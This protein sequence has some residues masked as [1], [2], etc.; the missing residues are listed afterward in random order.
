MDMY[1]TLAPRRAEFTFFSSK[2]WIFTKR[3]H[4]EHEISPQKFQRTVNKRSDTVAREIFEHCLGYYLSGNVPNIFVCDKSNDEIIS[5]NDIYVE[6]L[7]QS[8]MSE[9]LNLDNQSF[10]LVHVRLRKV[11]IDPKIYYCV[12]QRSVR[13]LNLSGKIPGLFKSLKDEFGV[14]YYACYVTSSFLDERLY[15]D[16]TGFDIRKEEFDNDTIF[17]DQIVDISLGDIDAKILQKI[18]IYLAPYLEE[19]RQKSYNRIVDFIET[20]APHYRPLLN[21]M[22]KERLYLSTNAVIPLAL[23]MGI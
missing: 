7:S 2:H 17:Q 13:S 4:V 3:L 23:A 1:R 6:N 8:I 14:F 9:E 12:N 10:K 15:P 18:E 16:R 5:L 20:K 19:S 22:S 21:R 11:N